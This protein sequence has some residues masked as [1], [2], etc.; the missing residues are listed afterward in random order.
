[1]VSQGTFGFGPSAA[2]ISLFDAN[3]ITGRGRTPQV[4]FVPPDYATLAKY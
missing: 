1:M 4:F 2:S 3:H